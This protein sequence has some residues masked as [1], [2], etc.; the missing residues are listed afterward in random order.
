MVAGEKIKDMAVL[1]IKNE[2]RHDGN[3][4]LKFNVS[5]FFTNF[6]FKSIFIVLTMYMYDHKTRFSWIETAVKIYFWT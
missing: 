6:S 3:W 4:T 5:F 2:S 1:L